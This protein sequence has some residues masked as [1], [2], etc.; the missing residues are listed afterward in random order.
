MQNIDTV[1]IRREAIR[2]LDEDRLREALDFMYNEGETSAMTDLFSSMQHIL[3]GVADIRQDLSA[4]REKMLNGTNGNIQDEYDRL[5]E[6]AYNLADSLLPEADT[7]RPDYYPQLMD[8][9]QPLHTRCYLMSQLTFHLLKHFDAELIESLYL[10]TMDDQPAQ[11]RVRAWVAITLIALIHSKRIDRNPRLQEQLTYIAETIKDGDTNLM[12]GLQLLLLQT[13]DAMKAKDLLRSTI[14]QMVYKLVEKGSDSAAETGGI[15]QTSKAKNADG[16]PRSIT[17]SLN[18]S[19]KDNTWLQTKEGKQLRKGI[20]QFVNLLDEGV[21]SQLENFEAVINVPFFTEHPEN[22]LTPF[23]L[24]NPE[25]SGR[26][27]AKPQLKKSI[28]MI[29]HS[30]MCETDKFSRLLMFESF[31]AGMLQ[32]L[33]S[34]KNATDEFLSKLRGEQEPEQEESQAVSMAYAL[35]AYV[36]DLF[37]YCQFS[38]KVSDEDNPFKHSMLFLNSPWLQSTIDHQEEMESLSIYLCKKNR[39]KEALAVFSRRLEK[40]LCIETAKGWIVAA[41]N[42]GTVSHDEIIDRLYQFADLYPESA[43]LQLM[44]GKLLLGKQRWHEAELILRPACKRFS[45]NLDMLRNLAYAQLYMGQTDEALGN[46]YRCDFLQEGDCKTN[47]VLAV[48]LMCKGQHKE[49]ER[50]I[51]GILESNTCDDEDLIV[52]GHIALGMGNLEEAIS[53]YQRAWYKARRNKR[54]K[55]NTFI[56]RLYKTPQHVKIESLSPV[57]ITIARDTLYINLQRKK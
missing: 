29:M 47:I 15:I 22:W 32:T 9:T 50:Y 13:D 24:E 33:D 55:L 21:D 4:L 8:E 28:D 39:W 42:A 25:V 19:D 3:S 57:F 23:T 35:R 18:L 43:D 17:V 53:R 12:M 26:L 11:L 30:E 41:Q 2:L 44:L 27:Q 51:T 20:S 37:R 6:Q 48:A 14:Q 45:E 38:G 7:R 46:L 36:H 54:E 52:G 40:D 34:L 5:V 31:E 56:D 49:A 1:L 16:K 10:F